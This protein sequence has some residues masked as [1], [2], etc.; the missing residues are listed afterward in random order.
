MPLTRTVL[1]RKGR[2]LTVEA[3]FGYGWREFDAQ[4]HQHLIDTP[5]NFDFVFEDFWEIQGQI[6]ALLGKVV[7]PGHPLDGLELC[8]LPAPCDE[9][10]LDQQGTYY[11]LLLSPQRGRLTGRQPP[12]HFESVDGSGYPEYRGYAGK[13][14][15]K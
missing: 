3:I 9:I 11:F 13:I 6:V 12:P 4:R 2:I 14:R 10:D 7:Q 8:A 15:I 1:S 5:S